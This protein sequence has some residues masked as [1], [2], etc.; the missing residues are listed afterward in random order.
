GAAETFPGATSATSKSSIIT[1][2]INFLFIIKP[3][4]IFDYISTCFVTIIT[5]SWF[6]PYSTEG[7]SLL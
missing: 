5:E 7:L 3:L 2:D 1:T 6:H 4:L